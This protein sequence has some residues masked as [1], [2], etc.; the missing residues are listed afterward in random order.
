MNQ[1]PSRLAS[2]L[3][4]V[5]ATIQE[6]GA[7]D[8]HA[9]D[10]HAF[11]AARD[12]TPV[13]HA[14]LAKLDASAVFVYRKLVHGTLRSAIEL[15]IPRTVRLLGDAFEHSLERFFA[16]QLSRSHYLRDVAFELV[17][18]EGPGWPPA[19][20]DLARHELL[21]F[22]VAALPRSPAHPPAEGLAL[23]RGVLFDGAARLARYDHPVH[24]IADELPPARETWLLVYRTREHDLVHLSL[25]PLAAYVVDRLL[26]GET[27]QRSIELACETC[28]ATLTDEL[29]SG[30]AKV[31]ADLADRGVLL[32]PRAACAVGPVE[33]GP[34][35]QDGLRSQPRPDS[36]PR[37][38]SNEEDTP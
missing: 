27:L 18:R 29:L 13:D 31:L 28:S 15:E 33:D 12:L 14:E 19:L 5:V 34:S 35:G 6:P 11:F 24:E 4:A 25:T 2:L 9:R 21:D 36:P 10:P 8:R 30:V 37:D 17:E 38:V 22:E 3:S 7:P 23:D 16:E 32:G 20:F 1:E 26:A